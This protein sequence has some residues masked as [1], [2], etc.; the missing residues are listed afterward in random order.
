MS[1]SPLPPGT[2]LG[3]YQVVALIATG[4]MGSVYQAI[5]TQLRRTVALKVLRPDLAAQTPDLERFRREAR[6]A[7]R[8]SHKHIVTLFGH[9]Y[10][11]ELDLH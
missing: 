11:S 3:K 2:R 9:E 7:A 10:D 6:L 5:D 1:S 8:L 4:G